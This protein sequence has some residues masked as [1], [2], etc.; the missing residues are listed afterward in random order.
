MQAIAN[1]ICGQGPSWT[2]L[3]HAGPISYKLHKTLWYD[4][5]AQD[6]CWIK[7]YLA[8]PISLKIHAG[9]NSVRQD[10]YAPTQSFNQQDLSRTRYMLDKTLSDRTHIYLHKALISRTYLVRDTCWT[11]LCPTG[12]ISTYT[13]L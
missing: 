9:Q 5:L 2:K 11:K 1:I 6:T 12:P 3:C 10:P 8:G 4:Q 7:Q 13:K